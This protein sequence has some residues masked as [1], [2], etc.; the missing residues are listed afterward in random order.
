MKKQKENVQ[1]KL[2]K[3]YRKQKRIG[4]DILWKKHTKR[5]E[6]QKPK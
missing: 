5:K 3:N 1:K 6:I 4:K 2:K